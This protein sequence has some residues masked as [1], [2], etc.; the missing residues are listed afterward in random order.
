MI[1]SKNQKV[2]TVFAIEARYSKKQKP[3]IQKASNIYITLYLPSYNIVIQ[4]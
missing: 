1:I 3:N 2:R 4:N